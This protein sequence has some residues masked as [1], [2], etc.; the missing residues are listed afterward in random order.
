MPQPPQLVSVLIGVS[1]PSAEP[2]EQSAQPA[3]QLATAQEPA[4]HVAV[5]LLRLQVMPQPPQSVSEASRVSQPF[6]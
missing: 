2:P 1:Q 3:S 5:A 4:A 6:E